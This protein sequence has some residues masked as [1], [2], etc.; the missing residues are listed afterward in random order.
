MERNATATWT[1]SLKT[2]AGRLNTQSGTLAQAPFSFPTR[3]GSEPG[4]N[5]E[6]LIAAAHA[7][8]FSMAFTHFAEAAGAAPARVETRAQLRFD[9]GAQGP[10]VTGVHLVLRADVPGLEEARFQEVARQAKENCLVSRLLATPVTLEARRW[11]G[12]GSAGD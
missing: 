10:S 1:G 11:A 12:E 8:C 3:F 7:G 2:G 4:T 9:F 6:E 5:P